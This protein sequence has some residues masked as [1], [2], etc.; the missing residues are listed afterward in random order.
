MKKV[1]EIL[2]EENEC[3]KKLEALYLLEWQAVDA[4]EFDQE[5]LGIILS[6]KERQLELLQPLKLFCQENIQ[7]DMLSPDLK[8]VQQEN[9]EL[10]ERLKLLGQKNIIRLRGRQQEMKQKLVKVKQGQKV[11][12]SYEP[13]YAVPVMFL[14]KR[15]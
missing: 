14:D 12:T 15:R 8:P 11:V 9:Q 6:R 2:A 3:L 13:N 10:F 1:A 5:R 4:E 7:T